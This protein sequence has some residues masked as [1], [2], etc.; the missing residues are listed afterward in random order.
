MRTLVLVTVVGLGCAS[1]PRVDPHSASEANHDHS[2]W[3]HAVEAE[4]HARETCKPESGACWRSRASP[5]DPHE[6]A[7]RDHRR[8]GTAHVLASAKLHDAVQR[9]CAGLAVSD[10]KASPFDHRQD[11]ATVAPLVASSSSAPAGAVVTFRPVPG[12]TAAWLQRLLDCHLAEVAAAGHQAADMPDCP[13]VARGITATVRAS[14][15]A[16]AVEIRSSD[17]GVAA[18]ILARAQRLVANRC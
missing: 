8:A 13:L 17:P 15:N 1:E 6:Q 9:A 12:M 2:E 14:G 3:S 11:L 16:L 7:D 5:D 18:D 10:R 4:A